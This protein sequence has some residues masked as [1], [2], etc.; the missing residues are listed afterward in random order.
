MASVHLSLRPPL[1]WPQPSVDA[2]RVDADRVDAD[3]V[4]AN[5]VDANRVDADRVDANRVDANS[6]TLS[7]DDMGVFSSQVAITPPSNSPLLTDIEKL[8][9]INRFT[10]I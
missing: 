2:D 7:P 4:D 8:D 6:V 10:L 9:F 1:Y 5:R 3:R